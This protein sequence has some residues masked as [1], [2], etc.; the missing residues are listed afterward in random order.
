MFLW[1]TKVDPSSELAE[2]GKSNHVIRDLFVP[3]GNTCF[4][5]SCIPGWEEKINTH[6]IFVVLATSKVTNY[7]AQGR[8]KCWKDHGIT[9][10]KYGLYL[11]FSVRALLQTNWAKVVINHAVLS[12]GFQIILQLIS[13]ANC[14]DKVKWWDP[15][16]TSAGLSY[17]FTDK[18][19]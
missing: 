7:S 1:T 3:L 9:D 6:E 17:W 4:P 8:H 5:W 16:S 18:A 14:W 12:R 13:S 10:K 11:S 2:S 19:A 15:C